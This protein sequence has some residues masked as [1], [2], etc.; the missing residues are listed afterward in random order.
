MSVPF[1]AW[2]VSYVVDGPALVF[3]ITANLTADERVDDKYQR[4]QAP[5]VTLAWAAGRLRAVGPGP[6]PTGPPRTDWLSAWLRPGA[7]LAEQHRCAP[8]RA[9]L[10][11]AEAA[12]A[13]DSDRWPSRTGFEVT[14]R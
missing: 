14:W 7:S 11:L 12:R 10:A 5:A 13:A 1:G 2:H 4:G 6:R 8:A 9:W 3:N